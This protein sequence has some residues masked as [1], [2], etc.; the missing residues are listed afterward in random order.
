[1]LKDEIE[2]KKVKKNPTLKDVMS[3]KNQKREKKNPKK[4]P[5]NQS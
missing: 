4:K 2:R 3:L 1:M 5:P